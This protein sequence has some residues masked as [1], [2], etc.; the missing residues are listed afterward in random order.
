MTIIRTPRPWPGYNVNRRVKF[1]GTTIVRIP[2]VQDRDFSDIIRASKIA[3][4]ARNKRGWGESRRQVVFL[5]IDGKETQA[6]TPSRV[7]GD[8]YKV[9][10]DPVSPHIRSTVVDYGLARVVVLP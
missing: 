6:L 8:W 1:A 5:T 4:D 9:K 7:D 2:G 10:G 3:V